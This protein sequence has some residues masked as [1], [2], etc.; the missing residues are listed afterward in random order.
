MASKENPLKP[1]VAFGQSANAVVNQNN[2]TPSPA[3]NHQI[4]RRSSRLF[5]STQSVKENSKQ[6]GPK[7]KTNKNNAPKSPSSRCS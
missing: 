6:Q 1:S 3:G 2:I 7:S 4:V 5:G